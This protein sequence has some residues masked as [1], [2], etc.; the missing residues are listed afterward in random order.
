MHN[1][2][3]IRV[4]FAGT[5]TDEGSRVEELCRLQGDIQLVGNCREMLHIPALVH[6][7]GVD[8]VYLHARDAAFAREVLLEVLSELPSAQV[9]VVLP[10]CADAIATDLLQHGARGVLAARDEYA[11]GVR[12][13]RAVHS[14]QI[15]GSRSVL[16]SIAEAAIRQML[17]ADCQSRSLGSLTERER[18]IVNLLRVGSSN[19]QIASQLNISDKTVKTHV[20]NIFGKLHVG[21]RQVVSNL[22]WGAPPES[23][24]SGPNDQQQFVRHRQ[25]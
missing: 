25:A 15:W 22:R 11:Q 13:I 7:Q 2:Q 16:S 21:R 9:L 20:Q 24:D 6:R 3:R 5:R 4:L 14:G 18:Q 10:A 1:G 17:E 12:A 23:S 8:I 19:K